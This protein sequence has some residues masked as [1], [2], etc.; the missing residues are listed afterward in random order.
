MDDSPIY[1]A[2][3][4][5]AGGNRD[6]GTVT[7]ELA[8]GLFALHHARDGFT[9]SM[10]WPGG[11]CTVAQPATGGPA[12][13][14]A[15]CADRIHRFELYP[16]EHKP[17]RNLRSALNEMPPGEAPPRRPVRLA[18][19]WPYACPA[20]S[21]VRIVQEACAFSSAVQVLPVVSLPFVVPYAWIR[22]QREAAHH[23]PE[24]IA[25]FHAYQAGDYGAAREHLERAL[26]VLP[27]D[28]DAFYLLLHAHLREHAF[29]AALAAA[30]AHGMDAKLRVSHLDN[31]IRLLEAWHAHRD[32]PLLYRE[33]KDREGITLIGT[34]GEAIT[35]LRPAGKVRVG[36][37][38]YSG[39]TTGS[40]AQPGTP[41]QVIAWD[42]VSLVVEAMPDGDD[43]TGPKP[44]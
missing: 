18:H 31:D 27:E 39:R 4:T 14:T 5:G 19:E 41:V 36:E 10:Y 38:V 25:G 30:V 26:Q 22:L 11:A 42:G 9:G 13:L 6:L 16:K 33:T 12:V 43:A 7:L 28:Y 21:V 23:G 17:F 32:E 20:R 40:Y 15:D 2:V 44:G 8:G 37:R 29:D 35:M 34:R 24:A 3:C 1:I